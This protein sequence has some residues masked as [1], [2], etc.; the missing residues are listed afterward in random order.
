MY[1]KTQNVSTMICLSIMTKDKDKTKNVDFS[2][3]QP[4]TQV[5]QNINLYILHEMPKRT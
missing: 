2:T 3:A 4:L 5:M 1:A